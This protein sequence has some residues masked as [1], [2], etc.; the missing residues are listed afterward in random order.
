MGPGQKPEDRFSCS[1]AYIALFIS[2]Y[3]KTTGVCPSP[4]LS[5]VSP[6]STSVMQEK[7]EDII[8]NYSSQQLYQVHLYN[9]YKISDCRGLE[10][11]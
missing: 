2:R 10:I 5:Y 4:V 7:L 6:Y 9:L 1:T 3:C 11:L 8:K